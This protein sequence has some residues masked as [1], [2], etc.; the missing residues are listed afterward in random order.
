MVEFK[1]H[2]FG[3]VVGAGKNHV[4]A[5]LDPQEFKIRSLNFTENNNR[6]MIDTDRTRKAQKATFT[7]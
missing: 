3:Q 2:D 6:T 7:T 1:I 5:F 4:K